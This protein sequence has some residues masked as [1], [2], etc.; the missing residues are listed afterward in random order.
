MKELYTK[1]LLAVEMFTAVQ[2]VA[3]DCSASIPKEQLTFGDITNCVWD[4]GDGVS[5]VFVDNSTC[6]IDGE[7]TGIVCYNAPTEDNFIFRS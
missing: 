2:T 7:E 6:F 3:R 1:P 4:L 5:T